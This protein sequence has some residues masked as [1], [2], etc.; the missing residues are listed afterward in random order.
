MSLLSYFDCFSTS[1]N[2]TIL[3]QDKYKT[4]FG[5][6]MTILC[7]VTILVFAYLFGQ[8]FLYKKNPRILQQT[9]FPDQY[10]PPF[11]MTRE[12]FVI[13]WRLTDGLLKPIDKDLLFY[14]KKKH[15]SFINN[16]TGN[17]LVDEKNIKS[18]EC[19]NTNS[20]IAEFNDKFNISQWNCIDWSDDNYTLGG[21]W[22][23]S[24]TNYI[25]IELFF[26]PEG[27][28]F[29]KE[30]KCT[31]FETLNYFLVNELYFEVMYPEFYFVPDE[32]QPLRVH[33]VNYY[34]QMK[35]NTIKTDRL[36][37]STAILYDD[38]GWFTENTKS[39]QVIGGV[40]LKSDT[41]YYDPSEY[42]K[43]GTSSMFYTLLLYSKKNYSKYTRHYM[44][45]QELAAIIGGFMKIVLYIG[46]ETSFIINKISRDN[47]MYGNFFDYNEEKSISLNTSKTPLNLG[48]Q[49]NIKKLENVKDNQAKV[50]SKFLS[51]STN[52]L[53]QKPKSNY[54]F[55][56]FPN[57]KKSNLESENN[58]PNTSVSNT[59]RQ[60]LN[61]GSFYILGRKMKFLNNKNHKDLVYD[62][63]KDFFLQRLDVVYYLK[64]LEKN[65]K[66]S[67]IL[68]NRHRNLAM[69]FLKVPNL[70][71]PQV[72]QFLKESLIK[73]N[74]GGQEVKE[75][76]IERKN[77]DALDQLDKEIIEMIDIV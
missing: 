18:Y 62:T 19:N 24:F 29:S 34:F 57:K 59:E 1:F 39:S 61:F 71:D 28:P 77:N 22:D 32:E 69:N 76:F 56:V 75:Y 64:N 26:C 17:I 13:P 16:S 52:I 41:Y 33:Y 51:N 10:N 27:K 20:K 6:I 47:E 67:C 48:L 40:Q 8:D 3:N 46:K 55:F 49:K 15:Y 73:Q 65:E 63:V 7:G 44:K 14:Y 2:F 5:G 36:F 4:N 12:N 38:I 45:F 21:F 70:S 35:L 60:K 23:G 50:G 68:L 25:L 72:L 58:N 9:V 30:N 11:K 42:G 74:K 53:K 43:E 31:D 54:N 66:I 37:F